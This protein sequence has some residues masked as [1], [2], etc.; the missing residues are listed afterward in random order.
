MSWEEEGKRASHMPQCSEYAAAAAAA[1]LCTG[2]FGYCSTILQIDNSTATKV[3][4]GTLQLHPHLLHLQPDSA[5]FIVV[6]CLSPSSCCCCCSCRLRAEV[7][8]VGGVVL[9]SLH[10]AVS[11]N[12]PPSRPTY[13]LPHPPR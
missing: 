11:H 4:H 12:V 1:D 7:V 9:G 2:S 5:T 13:R 3:R 6:A 10:R 8:H